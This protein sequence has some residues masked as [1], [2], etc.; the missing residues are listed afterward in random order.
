MTVRIALVGAGLIGQRHAEAIA[1]VPGVVL[2][3]VADPAEA[4]REVAAAQGARHF[5][6]LGEMIAADRP[7]GV[8]LATPNRHHVDGALD[9]IAAGLPVLVE[10]PLA[11]DL[12]GA[13]RIV[14]AAERAGVPVAVGHHRRHNPLI[15]RAKAEIAEGRLGQITAVQ[16][17]TW[18]M[19][20][21]EYFEVGWRRETGA[22]PVHLNLIH[23]IDLLRHLCGEVASVHAMESNAVRKNA[24]EDTTVILLRFESGALGTVNLSDT[25][26]APW[27]WELT[28]RENAAY[29]ATGES[30][31]WIG[32]THGSLALP[33]LALWSNPGKR[34]WWEPISATRLPFGLDDPLVRQ[35]RQFAAVIRGEEPPLVPASEG[36]RNQRVIEAVKNSAVT[37]GTIRLN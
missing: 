13:E 21:D 4:G 8:I 14:A 7:D 1:A 23:D 5:P 28:A 16:A 10:K 11:T 27:S 34:S 32:G 31:Y 33:N 9:C 18:F 24:V 26:V 19:K 29:P 25:I 2:S 37:G 3:A 22:G 17:T 20:P 30:C 15:A 6:T 36:L 35:I 12:A